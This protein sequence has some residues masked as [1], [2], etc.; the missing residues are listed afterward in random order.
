MNE[1]TSA[2]LFRFDNPSPLK[3]VPAKQTLAAAVTSAVP[4]ASDTGLATLRKPSRMIV[5]VS[6]SSCARSEPAGLP[7]VRHSLPGPGNVESSPSDTGDSV[8]HVVGVAGDVSDI[9]GLPP[10]SVLPRLG[11]PPRP[12]RHSV[13]TVDVL[14]HARKGSMCSEAVEPPPVPATALPRR[15]DTRQGVS[16]VASNHRGVVSEAPAGSGSV[17]PLAKDLKRS[18]PEAM[19]RR[20]LARIQTHEELQMACVPEDTGGEWAAPVDADPPAPGDAP[21]QVCRTDTL[22]SLLR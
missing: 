15:R 12:S 1:L 18:Q 7:R 13:G 3:Q 4:A 19:A 11:Q 5:P 20:V 10:A 2:V 21:G 9:W 8:L 6:S 22:R 17:P 14:R 16:G